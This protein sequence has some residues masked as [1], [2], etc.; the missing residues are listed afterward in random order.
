E[1]TPCPVPA[2]TQREALRI[3]R[4]ALTNAV[5]HADATTIEVQLRYPAQPTDLLRLT[6]RDNGRGAPVIAPRSGH[7]GVRNMV[8]SAHAVGGKLRFCSEAGRRWYLRLPLE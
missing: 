5:K 1:Q 4:E 7:F 8:E 6:I 3:T 2:Q